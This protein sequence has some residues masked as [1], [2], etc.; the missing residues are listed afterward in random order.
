[1]ANSVEEKKWLRVK[2]LPSYEVSD[3]GEVRRN[4]RKLRLHH[5]KDGY[6]QVMLGRGRTRTVHRLVA[7]AFIPNPQ[8]K[9][10][11]N[12]INRDRSDNRVENLEW[13]DAHYNVHYDGSRERAAASKS[14]P[15]IQLTTDGKQVKEWSSATE[16]GLCGY[17][18]VCICNCCNGKSETHSGFRWKY[19]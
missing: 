4:N 5:R 11:V 7:E 18:R 15:V 19:K 8:N 9:P 3:G 2:G 10:M 12:H 6:V 14:K 17:S 1:M 13:C 16:A